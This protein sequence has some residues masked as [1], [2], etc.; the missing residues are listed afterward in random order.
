MPLTATI[1]TE[2]PAPGTAVITIDGPLDVYS[3]PDV[4]AT[5]IDLINEGRYRQVVDLRRVDLLDST[6]LGVIVGALKR[7][8]ARGGNLALVVDL[9]SRP[10]NVLRIT[11]VLKAIGH[12]ASADE[13]PV[14]AA[15]PQPHPILS[16]PHA[17][18]AREI[19]Q[20]LLQRQVRA[21]WADL[22]DGDTIATELDALAGRGRIRGYDYDALSALRDE[23]LAELAD[24]ASQG[25][26]T[27]TIA[28]PPA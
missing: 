6:G 15:N 9:D 24:A 21:C 16:R 20:K 3:A 10:G 4:R 19:A 12:A 7:A 18:S 1:N 5:L 28:A 8:R 2:R 26:I 23:V 11:G 22:V 14:L 27:V 13:A 25:R 17:P